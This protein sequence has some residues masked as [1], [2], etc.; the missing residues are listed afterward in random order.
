MLFLAGLLLTLVNAIA[1]A[2][3]WLALRRIRIRRLPTRSAATLVLPLTG[4]VPGLGDLFACLENQTDPIRRVVVAVESTNDPA[5]AAVAARRATTRL[6]ID[7]VIA[8][9]STNASQKVCN[10]VAAIGAL[11]PAD[12]VVVFLDADIRPQ[13]WWLAT[14]QSPVVGGRAA[15]ATGYRW[16]SAPV[17][18]LGAVIATIDRS[19][20]MV[21]FRRRGRILW[22]GSTAIRRDVLDQIDYARALAG[23]VSDDLRLGEALHR[24]G[25]RVAQLGSVLVPTPGDEIRGIRLNFLVRQYRI[26]RVNRPALHALAGAW[27]GLRLALWSA[28]VL[29]LPEDTLASAVL[30]ADLVASLVKAAIRD[31]I[32]LAIGSPDS[33]RARIGQF[34]CAVLSPLVDIVHAIGIVGGAVSRRIRWGHVDYLLEAPGR[35]LVLARR[36]PAGDPA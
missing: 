19:I 10:L 14:L 34:A 3:G 16:Q 15:A 13:P 18:A 29:Q 35:T 2:A 24:A 8:G 20:A 11:E 33:T 6:R 17:T 31:R 12:R 23:A 28:V 25:H 26:V 4:R 7:V 32:A 30:A 27:I 21:P 22:G 36:S 5:F 1:I 9:P